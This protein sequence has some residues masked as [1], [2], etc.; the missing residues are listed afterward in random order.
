MTCALRPHNGWVPP[1]AAI[2][3]FAL[4]VLPLVL[5]PGASFTLVSARSLAGDRRGT[6]LVILGTACGI[7]VH[8]ILAGMGL[9]AVV[10]RSAELYRW[11]RL[12][13]ALYLIGLGLSLIWKSYRGHGDTSPTPPPRA[14]ASLRSTLLGALVANVLNVKAA[15][16]Y[17]TLA[18]QFISSS[19]VGIWSMLMLAA[20][21]IVVM[22]AWLGLWTAGLTQLSGR[23]DPRRWTRRIDVAGGA[24]LVGLGTRSAIQGR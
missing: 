24:V 17:L 21:H 14:F 18:P 6:G 12:I 9:A 16:I 7:V 1:I 8:A 10:L 20:A 15:T 2:L 19:Q 13:G 5:T 22:L 3:A 11:I 23:L 4:S